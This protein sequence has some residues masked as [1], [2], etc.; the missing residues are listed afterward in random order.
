MKRWQSGAALAA[1]IILLTAWILSGCP[2]NDHRDG[3]GMKE[4]PRKARN[5]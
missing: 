1:V 4:A 3:G 2:R 5:Y